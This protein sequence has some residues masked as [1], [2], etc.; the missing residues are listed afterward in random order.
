MKYG[1]L[2]AIRK[3]YKQQFFLMFW[4]EYLI[5][6]NKLDA[7]VH[8]SSRLNEINSSFSTFGY[9][10]WSTQGS[11][12]KKLANNPQLSYLIILDNENLIYGSSNAGLC[13]W[14]AIFPKQSV[15]RPDKGQIRRISTFSEKFTPPYLVSN[16][17]LQNNKVHFTS[18]AHPS[19]CTEVMLVSV[20]IFEPIS[21]S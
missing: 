6:I 9:C 1:N 5:M 3:R 19:V 11:N 10:W 20:Y 16:H 8:I 2:M 4:R 18:I 14:Q 17:S 15:L 13:R 7:W 21:P 12:H